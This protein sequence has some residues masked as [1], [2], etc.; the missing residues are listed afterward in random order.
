MAINDSY[1]VNNFYL[2]LLNKIITYNYN[3]ARNHLL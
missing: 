2:N 3:L 1:D